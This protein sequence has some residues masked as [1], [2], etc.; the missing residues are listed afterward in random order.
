MTNTWILLGVIIVFVVGITVIYI[1]DSPDS[2]IEYGDTYKDNFSNG[3]AELNWRAYL[4]FNHDNLAG[5]FDPSAPQ[6]GGIGV[7]DN[8]NAGGFA[9]L[10]YAVTPQVSDFY[11]GAQVYC[12]ATEGDNGP[13]QGIAFLVD[14]IDGRFYRLVCDF[15]TNDSSLN[16]A[17]VGQDTNNFPA[18]VRIWSPEEIPGGAKAGWH[19]MAV[20]VIDGEASVYWDGVEIED[21]VFVDR[22]SNGYAGAYTNYVGGFGDAVTKIDTFTLKE[23]RYRQ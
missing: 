2:S 12:N 13:L 11:F 4:Y 1:L 18:Y 15:K 10:S 19:S 3:E 6:G 8:S 14:P 16:L 20:E 7:L 21:R 23:I 9:S 5:S 22:I 17:Y